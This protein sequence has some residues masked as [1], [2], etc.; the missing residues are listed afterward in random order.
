MSP[1]S[2]YTQDEQIL[3]MT[4]Y[5]DLRGIRANPDYEPGIFAGC[6]ESAREEIANEPSFLDQTEQGG[7]A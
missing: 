3:A 7:E 2:G 5:R 4:L 1:A 6:L